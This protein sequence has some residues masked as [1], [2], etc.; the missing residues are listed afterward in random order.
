MIFVH[1]NHATKGGSSEGIRMAKTIDT[2]ILFIRV[3]MM[4]ALQ[5]SGLQQL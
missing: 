3:S 4:L 2:D 1:N 5:E